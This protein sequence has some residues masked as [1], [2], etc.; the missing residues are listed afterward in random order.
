MAGLINTAQSEFQNLALSSSADN[1]SL[2]ETFVWDWYI[3]LKVQY[4]ANTDSDL[5][6]RN[7][8]SVSKEFEDLWQSIPPVLC[9]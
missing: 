8:E 3:R 7:L 2:S 6:L 9:I 5:L 1:L 4:P